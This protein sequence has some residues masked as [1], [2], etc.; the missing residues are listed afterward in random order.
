VV[1]TRYLD[2]TGRA[3]TS[4]LE[5][6]FRPRGIAIAGGLQ[7]PGA[8]GYHVLTSL[9]ESGFAGHI[10]V[11]HSRETSVQGVVAYTDLESIPGPVELLV[12]ATPANA[13]AEAVEAIRK[14]AFHRKDLKVVVAIG[15]GYAEAGTPDGFAR[16]KDLLQGCMAAGVRLVGPNCQGVLDNRSRLDT[17]YLTGIGR[18]A[19]GISLL[20]QSGSMGAWLA[21]EWASQ[22]TPVGLCKFI[23]LGNMADVDMTEVLAYLETDPLT[24]AIGLYVEG[25]AQAKSLLEAAG[26]AAA[27]K[28]VVVLKVGRSSVGGEAV[29]AHTGLLPGPDPIYEAAFRQ[30]GLIRAERTDDFAGIL[31]AFDRLPLPL[32]GRVAVLTNAGGPGVYAL[33]ALMRYGLTPGRFSNATRMTLAATL[34]S[35]ALVG[36]P[37]GY[38]DM[39]ASVGPRQMAQAVAAV[40]RDPGIDAVFPLFIPTRFNAAEQMAQEMLQLL[41]GVMRNSLDKPLLQVLLGGSSVARARRLLEEN[42]ILTFGSPDAAA[43]ALGALLRFSLGRQ[44]P[45][46]GKAT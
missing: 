26:S 25:H 13:V 22:P 46:N 9:L 11:V 29:R 42:A 2:S 30:F 35:C 6:L 43:A 20:S 40:L 36:E 23:S 16:Q 38:V 4:S 19:G 34:P 44:S 21:L 45:P 12:L 3:A 15:G 24:R 31:N 1:S 39:T 32:G 37:Q 5:P 10:A 14:R 41:P 28:P 33:D 27:R 7:S 8:A 17:T 18:R